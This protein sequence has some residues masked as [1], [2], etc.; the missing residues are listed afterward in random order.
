[1]NKRFKLFTMNCRVVEKEMPTLKPVMEVTS[2]WMWILWE[3]LKGLETSKGSFFLLAI[4]LVSV[5]TILP[6][7][8]FMYALD[9]GGLDASQSIGVPC[10]KHSVTKLLFL[11]IQNDEY[12]LENSQRINTHRNIFRLTKM[13]LLIITQVN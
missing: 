7:L 5:F 13:N 10:D 8:F 3:T 4:V 6:F 2:T 9:D 1:M 12:E 11:C